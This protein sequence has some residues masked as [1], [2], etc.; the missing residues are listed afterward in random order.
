M[1]HSDPSP[2]ARLADQW[3][4]AQF[5]LRKPADDADSF[6]TVR[7]VVQT[8]LRC[9]ELLDR[10][11]VRL[12]M[13]RGAL[14]QIL[15]PYHE[16]MSANDQSSAA[17]VASAVSAL[18]GRMDAAVVEDMVRG[19]AAFRAL[20]RVKVADDRDVDQASRAARMLVEFCDGVAQAADAKGTSPG[21]VFS[22]VKAL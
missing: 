10:E 5:L 13:R 11:A 21:D 17:D 12:G 3:A 18:D 22:E 4:E 14:S 7:D 1:A 9:F 15:L 6:R 19:L 2:L 8:G 20:V 16:N